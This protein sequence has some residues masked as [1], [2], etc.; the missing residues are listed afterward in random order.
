M[1]LRA[2]P[3]GIE[4]VRIEATDLDKIVFYERQSMPMEVRQTDVFARWFEGLRDRAARARIT[5]RIRRL[6]LG[7]PGDVKPVGSGV[8]EM[9]IDHGPGYRVYFVARG[10]TIVILLCGGDKRAQH[11]DI[12]RALELASEV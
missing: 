5:A 6:S 1:S 7:N 8:S 2:N 11:R 9:R 10:D 3:S 12:K 4:A